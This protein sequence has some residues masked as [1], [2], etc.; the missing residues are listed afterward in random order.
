MHVTR[1]TFPGPATEETWV[2]G[3]AGGNARWS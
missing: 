3:S 2:T 1:L